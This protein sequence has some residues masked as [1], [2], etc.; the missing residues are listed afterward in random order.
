MEL[1]AREDLQKGKSTL[2]L[3]GKHLSPTT[4]EKFSC[5]LI[6]SYLLCF[7]QRL[8]TRSEKNSRSRKRFP[9]AFF[10]GKDVMVLFT[11]MRL[12]RET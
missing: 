4:N 10:I 5:A 2:T 7:L 12:S 8:Q 9:R 6:K 3:Q 1:R 11:A